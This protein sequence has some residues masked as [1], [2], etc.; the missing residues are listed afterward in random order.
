[1]KG[2]IIMALL[3]AAAASLVNR[4]LFMEIMRRRMAVEEAVTLFTLLPAL[5]S[6]NLFIVGVVNPKYFQNS[7]IK[8][9]II[10]DVDIAGGSSSTIKTITYHVTRGNCYLKTVDPIRAGTRCALTF[11]C[12]TF[13]S[14]QVPGVVIWDS[15]DEQK[16]LSG[17]LVRLTELPLGY[18]LFLVKYY[19]YRVTRGLFFNLRL[20]GFKNIRQLFVRPVSVMQ[21]E[22]RFSEGHMLFE[23]GEEGKV[24]YLIRKGKVDI[25]KTLDTG[26][27]VRMVTLSE[28]DIFGEMAIVGNQPRLATAVCRT[29]CLLAVA[30]ADNLDVL[31]ESNP[32]F[33]QRLIKIFANRLHASEQTLLKSMAEAGCITKRKEEQLFDICKMFFILSRGNGAGAL[34]DGDVAVLSS[35]LGMDEKAVRALFCRVMGAGDISTLEQTIRNIISEA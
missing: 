5:Y 11:T 13:A 28:G 29:E 33:T 25:I 34:A 4:H 21:K 18:R 19:L 15:R 30:E 3:V 9:P 32:V 14:P 17:T 26:E 6:L 31:I 27:K 24:F 1:V 35:Q 20:P 8:I 2:L 16:Q 10:I 7:M 12:S 22:W 23:Q